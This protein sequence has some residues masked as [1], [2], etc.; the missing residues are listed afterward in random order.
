MDLDL[1]RLDREGHPALGADI[2]AK[3]DGV[4]DVLGRFLFGLALTHAARDRG[5]L[6]DPC[7]VFVAIEGNSEFHGESSIAS[8]SALPASGF[9]A[10]SPPRQIGRPRAYRGPAELPC[11]GRGSASGRE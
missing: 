11:R 5:A 10:V 2:Q 3:F 9:T 7:A 6:D 1:L 4:S 8:L